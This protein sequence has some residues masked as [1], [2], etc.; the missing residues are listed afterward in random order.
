[1]GD[2][3]KAFYEGKSSV[4]RLRKLADFYS[5]FSDPSF[6]FMDGETYTLIGS[7]LFEEDPEYHEIVRDFIRTCIK[8]KWVIAGFDWQVW[9]ENDGAAFFSDMILLM[10]AEAL[11]LAKVLTVI[12][13]R[14]HANHGY[15]VETYANGL[16]LTVLKRAQGLS[17]LEPLQE[18]A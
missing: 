12:F 8:D 1:M 3:N 11:E 16:L 14:E 5:R 6:N 2:I 10:N 4:G 13:G 18:A 9:A 7:M 17:A 15:L